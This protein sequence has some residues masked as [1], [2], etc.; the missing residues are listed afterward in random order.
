MP[1]RRSIWHRTLENSADQSLTDSLL[2]TIAIQLQRWKMSFSR[3]ILMLALHI[4]I[5]RFA[6][7]TEDSTVADEFD[8]DEGETGNESERDFY[9][10]VSESGLCRECSCPRRPQCEVGVSVVVDGC[11]CC[12]MCA[13]Q[14]GESCNR[15]DVC[16][17]HRGLLCDATTGTCK[18]RPGRS[19]F[20]GGKWYENGEL[21]SPSC[22]LSCSCIDGDIG[23][24]SKCKPPPPGCT[25]PRRMRS[26]DNCCGHWRCLSRPSEYAGGSQTSMRFRGSCMIQTTDWSPCS[27]TCGFGLSERVTNENENCKLT[28]E[29]RLCIVRPCSRK[30]R[31]SRKSKKSC[32]KTMRHGKRVQFSLSGCLT[33]KTYRPRYCGTCRHADKCCKPNITKT[34]DMEFR[35]EGTPADSET[36]RREVQPYVFKRKMMWIQ[37]CVCGK[38]C[39]DSENDIFSNSYQHG[40]NNDFART[41]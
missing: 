27:K 22:R 41:I 32:R 12:K 38:I 1:T 25:Y 17:N 23:C 7:G 6:V 24:M 37:N 31:P 14:L 3:S 33:T 4:A 16:D 20:V 13:R 34:I 40:L 21:F 18:A 9:P 8:I 15:R 39:Q 29:R 2:R 35:C 19:C 30:H 10:T 28:K 26:P 5:L 11:G 36:G